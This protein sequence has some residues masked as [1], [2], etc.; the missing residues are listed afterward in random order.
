MPLESVTHIGDLDPAN[1]LAT[2][3]KKKGDD[4]V[5][6]LKL[7]LRNDFAGFT[8]AICVTGT[9]GGAVNSYTLTSATALVA[10]GTK[11]AAV[12][13]PI[14][15]N[16]GAATLN[17]SGL[18]AKA[19]KRVDGSDVIAGDLV[20]G[21]LYIGL[22]DG[23]EFRLLSPTKNYIDQ[24]AFNSALP[25][26]AGNSGK[27]I[28]TNGLSASWEPLSTI[29]SG[30]TANAVLVEA[31][32]ASL[33]DITSGTFTQTFTAAAALGSGWYCW[34]RNSG[35]GD[36]TL[37]PNGLELIDGLASYVMYPGETRLV[38]CDGVG[39]N[40]VVLTPFSKTFTSSGT[41]IKPPGYSQFGGVIWGG[42]SSGQK[43]GAGTESSG[44]GGGGSLDFTIPASSVAATE[45][46]IIGAGGVGNSV[47]GG[48]T[49]IGSWA[50]VY[51]PVN[52]RDGGSAIPGYNWSASVPPAGYEGVSGANPL[53]QLLN[54]FYG[55]GAAKDTANIASGSSVHGGAA[56]GGVSSSGVVQAAGVSKYGGSG[57][58][59]GD[60]VSGANGVAPGGGGGAT[61]TGAK[62][63][64]G[65]RG[66][67]RI[68]GIN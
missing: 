46:I 34:L 15:S 12:F 39:F 6:N 55:G 36:I 3:Q 25:A 52:A 64:D 63:G 67:A 24:L 59:A 44:G 16:T 17:I 19:I 27:F 62:S 18:G 56:G 32:R 50:N 31:D 37:D 10:Y 42:G 9:D 21:A 58:A 45:P 13:S 35:T 2:D 40:S 26:Q 4:H 22:F 14:A 54:G 43:S 65:A 53:Q 20:A 38:Q 30:R 61:R 47:V 66:E 60:A 8:G 68:W 57:G 7:A 1:P 49:S 28:R 11:M 29:R 5:R 41:F 51:P 48:A 23:T 33:I